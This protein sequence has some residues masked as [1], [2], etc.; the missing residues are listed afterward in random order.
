MAEGGSFGVTESEG[1][2]GFPEPFFLL[3]ITN[4]MI[5]T[6][7]M[8]AATKATM[9]WKIMEITIVMAVKI[10]AIMKVAMLIKKPL[11][12]SNIGMNPVRTL[13]G[14]SAMP[15]PAHIKMKPRKRKAQIVTEYSL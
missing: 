14:A 8:I 7:I 15:N 13:N 3:E 5:A 6:A 11:T 1:P 10:S 4:P 2:V 12:D 9:L